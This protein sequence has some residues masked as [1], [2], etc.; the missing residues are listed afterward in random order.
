MQWLADVLSVACSSALL[1]RYCFYVKSSG[2]S[3][4]LQ[5][6]ITSAA[7]SAH[8]SNTRL[9][10]IRQTNDFKTLLITSNAWFVV[11]V[12]VLICRP[13]FH[14]YVTQYV[15]EVVLYLG[16]W[17]CHFKYNI[18]QQ[19]RIYMQVDEQLLFLKC[20]EF[21]TK[22]ARSSVYCTGY[23]KLNKKDITYS[24][25]WM[26]FITSCAQLFFLFFW[27]VMHL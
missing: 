17:K 10:T 21:V 26:H 25:A 24:V 16:R 19:Y 2:A 14:W 13:V 20:T 18:P 1:R 5:W 9:S 27:Q 4:C 7:W 12:V 6:W 15:L 22:K 3:W 8:T 11:V 23:V